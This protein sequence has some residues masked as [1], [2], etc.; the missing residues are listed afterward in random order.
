MNKCNILPTIDVDKCNILLN[1]DLTNARDY[2]GVYHSR[3]F[4][5]GTS[6][7]MSGV[8]APNTHYFNDE[9]I[10]DF[11]TFVDP[12]TK[13]GVLLSC[14]KSHLSTKNGCDVPKLKY[15]NEQVIGIEPNAYWTFITAGIIGPIGKD[16][17]VWTPSV[18]EDGVIT[19]TKD[20]TS[21]ESITPINI[22][23]PK[24]EQGVQGI[25]GI[26]GEKGDENIAFGCPEDFS[27]GAPDINK[28]WYDPCDRS[29]DKFSI[30]DF[31]YQAYLNIG[32]N[33]SKTNFE[34]AFSNLSNTSW[35]KVQFAKNFEALGEPTKDKMGIVW[36]IPSNNPE[37]HNSFD[38]YL[39][40]QSP[41]GI[42][43][44]E[45]WGSD[46]KKKVQN[47]ALNSAANGLVIT[48]TDS[49][50][51]TLLLGKATVN[52]DGL[53][54]KEDKK[55]LDTLTPNTVEIIN[56]LDSNRTDAALSAAQGKA[57]KTSIDN[58]KNSLSTAKNEIKQ[59]TDALNTKVTAVENIAFK[60]SRYKSSSTSLS[61]NVI[62]NVNSMTPNRYIRLGIGTMPVSWSFT[63]PAFK[64]DQ[65][66]S[67][68][69]AYW[70]RKYM[71]IIDN[72]GTNTYNISIPNAKNTVVLDNITTITV[73]PN[74]KAII[75]AE[76][77]EMSLS[78]VRWWV[79]SF[80][81]S[82]N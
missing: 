60:L 48:Y 9:Y 69:K 29:A 82:S 51:T 32:G 39:V 66:S 71:Y 74:N 70:G 7:K 31:L 52:A 18:S 73:K 57:I 4:Y 43:V 6:F 36:M 19:W 22:K 5:K 46:P 78:N 49:T 80:V 63:L 3:D 33:L 45:K 1:N 72:I 61:Y 54:S 37:T 56:N 12:E 77:E 23:G 40:I 20:Y 25:Q 30:T 26:Q 10:V 15:E 65:L 76:A 81:S 13:V 62:S 55:K 21:P 79:R 53:M 11:V 17:M 41:E 27:G 50:S 59:T 8:W 67:D 68:M 75:I 64:F 14:N 34:T 16:G 58:L 2:Y 28:I 47:V 24:G 44:W 35:F 42:F 38:E